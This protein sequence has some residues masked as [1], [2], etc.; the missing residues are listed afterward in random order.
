MLA[1]VA[2]GRAQTVGP[3]AL[4][5]QA[6]DEGRLVT[7]A[8]NT[9]P[10]A[11]GQHD[12]GRVSD[13]LH[14]DMYLQL[15][16]SPEQELAAAQFVESLTDTTSPNFHHWITA[17]EYGR[18]FG[19]APED[20][21]TVSRWLQTHGFTVNTVHANNM[22]IDFSG[23][24]GQV[25]E[26]LHTEIH[27]LDV[28]GERHFANMSDPQI[29][30]ALLP[31]VTG[32]VS[33]SNFKPHSMLVPKAQYTVSPLEL[34]IVPGDLA[35]I[36]NLN[37]AFSAGFTGLG[38]TVV[39]V[40]DTDLYNGTGD[41]SVFRQTF[42]LT[43]Y[44]SGSLT[45]VHP[46]AGAGGTCADPGIND[47]DGEAAL[48]VEWASAAAPNAAIVMASC[49]DTTNF[50]GFIA[51]QNMLTD[52]GALPSVV[53][54][55][56]G[57]S[58]TS[59]GASF[60]AYIDTL[61]Q[62]ATAAGV[63]VFV[64]TGDSA[65]AV[66]DRDSEVAIHGITASSFASTPYNVAVGGT[67]FGDFA[68]GTTSAFW[69]STNGTYYNSAESY[70][71][72]I[73]WNDSCASAVW[74]NYEGVSTTY[75]PSGYCN[76][77]YSLL[78]T[79]GG[80]GGP[81]GCATGSPSLS[82]VVS[83]TCAGY[84]KP[85]WQSIP[86]NP[87]DGVRDLPDV[88]LFASNGFWGHYY[89][90]CIS[91]GASCTGPPSDWAGAGGT[92]FS[93]PIMAGIQAVINQALGTRNVG[94][95]NPVYYQIGQKQYSASGGEAA[96]NSSTGPASTCSFNDVT[97]GDM[98]VPCA[99]VNCYFDGAGIGVLS[100]SSTSYQP[101]F[102]TTPGWDFAT[103]IGTV[104]AFN[105]LNAYVDSVASSVAPP[106]PVLISPANGATGVSP[107]PSLTWNA[108]VGATSYDVYFG[109]ATQPPLVTNTPDIVYSPGTLS[110]GTTYYWAVGAR[111]KLGANASAAR[112]FTTGCVA[113]LNPSSAVAPAGGST[114]TI[115]VNA[116]TGCVW[117][118]ASN[119]TWI[120]ITSGASGSGN[121]TVGYTVAADTAAQRSG[122]IT[123]AGQTFTVTQTIYPLISTLAGGAMPP[124]AAPG[125][126][127]SIPISFGIAVDS[128]GN[129]YFSSPNLNAVF[130]ADP[131]GVVTRIA[132]TGASGYSGDNGPALSATLDSPQGVAV[133]S[134][135]DVYIAD[136]YNSRIRRV[137]AAGTITTV[138]GDGNCC[139]YTGDGGA[140]INAQIGVP[141][142]LAVDSSGDLY[143]SDTFNN[144]VRK[145]AT[146]GIIATVA[147]NGAY[148]YSGDNGPATSAEFKDP[149]SVAVD[150]S[151]NLYIADSYNYRIR[152]VSTAGTITTVAGNGIYG[153]SGDGG[154]AT[155]AEL[156]E[157]YGVAVDA[158]GDLYIAD[159]ANERIRKVNSSGTI[160]TVAGNGAAGY[161]GDGGT[162]TSAE[163]YYPYGVAVS[164]AGSLY[165]SDSGNARIRSV[166]AAGTISTVVGGATGDGGLGEFGHL[167][168]PYGVARDNAGNTYIAD[169]NNN[170]VR[171][172]A[173]NGTITTVAGTGVSGYL[174]DNGPAT[175]AELNSPY[176][177][178]V[179]GSG[180]LYIADSYNSR[181]RKVNS[182]GTITTVAGN[183]AY[184]YSGDGGAA[185]SASLNEPFG[186]AVDAAGDLYI[187]D[188]YN[189]RVRKVNSSGTI[190]TVAGNGTYG[191]S[192][193]GGVATSAELR[194][195][196][197]VAVD[198]SGNV[199]IADSYN[200]RIRMVSTSGIITTVAGNGTYGYS[201]DGGT[202]TSASLFEPTGVAVDSTGDLYIADTNN[203]RIR[204]VTSGTITTVA[205]TGSA[206]YS[207][208]G[209]VATVAELHDPYG[210][211]VDAAGNVAIADWYNNSARLLT[212][213][214]T[215]PVLSIQGA[216]TGAFTQG[217]NGA[218]YTLTVS[219]AFG[220][221]TTSGTVTVN[222]VL[223][224]G[225]TLVSMAGTGWTCTSP[226]ACTR[227]DG[228]NG[229]SSY[230]AIT[231]TVNVSATAPVQ[232]TNQASVSGGGAEAAA[233]ATDLTLISQPG[234]TGSVIPSVT[235][236]PFTSSITVAQALMVTVAVSGG[237]SNPTPT[238]TVIL[239][240]GLY[241]SAAATLSAG[242]AT[243]DIPAGT[244]ATGT[245][246]LTVSYTPD[247]ASS[248]T[249]KGASGSSSVTVVPQGVTTTLALSASPAS[250]SY[251]QQVVLSATLTPYSAQGNST[252][253]ETV[254][255]Y[256]DGTRLGTG[257]LSSGVATLNV[258]AL[259]AGSDGLQAVYAGD[260]NF[261]TSIS[262]ALV[263]PVS[264][265]VP[266]ISF[267]IP[268]HTY[269]DAPFTL[270]ATSNSSGAFTYSVVS[271]PATVSG[272]TATL[273]GAGTVVLQASQAAAGNYAA[274]S[275]NAS[276]TVAAEVPTIGF[277]VPNHTYGDAPFTVAATSN[278]TGAFTYSVV[279]GPATIS[280]SMVT[281]TGAGTVVLQ[282][283]QV[284]AGNYAAGSQ[285][286]PFAVGKNS[287]SV[288]L[289]A[290]P[291]PVLTLNAVS[292]TATVA[293]SA[294][295]PTG[296][297]VFSDSGMTIG[298]A[299]LG[300]GAAAITL[301][302]LAVGPHSITA[303]YSGDTNF[304]SVTSAA[305]PEA[306]EDFTFSTGGTGSS[307]TV[308][309][310]G[311]ASYTIPVSVS[312]GTTVPAAVAFSVS[313]LPTGYTAT[314]TPSS[315]P[316]GSGATNVMLSVQVPQSAVLEENG[317]LM[318]LAAFCVLLLPF[319]GR[320]RRSSKWL[321]R[322]AFVTIMLAGA[323]SVA[324]MLGCVQSKSGGG[325]SSQPQSYTLTV[326]ATSGAL[327]HS[328]A[329]T[330]TVQ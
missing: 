176:S 184:A 140:A 40:E 293:S 304:N 45:Q 122:T 153:Y 296:S 143:L 182:S 154:V 291:N 30:E 60:N 167:N 54:I 22:V 199:Y 238:G 278:S 177:V 115:S 219:N 32:V 252:N 255:F 183:G 268:N 41:W 315:L 263:F 161:S 257:A 286:G 68:S 49:A 206:G 127:V 247:S 168:Q 170:R 113:A 111:N 209:G 311:T 44:A 174:G 228:L 94:N 303:A 16:R 129:T 87:S 218:T 280:G 71:R 2:N 248:S 96:C 271:G 75:G 261:V 295:V 187:A 37:P 326:T 78:S 9:R 108:S 305:V 323:V 319:A 77:T 114:G 181:V 240:S 155:S 241:T 282:A 312:G 180:N 128:S 243:I 133:D 79:I 308:Q 163:L 142:G 244:L 191:Y 318:P 260:T 84:A 298:T 171:K 39:V 147:G 124:T 214:G 74:A 29:P 196:W 146:S 99:G 76:S 19:A 11:T 70:V 85:S 139:S 192:G 66:A 166:S 274:G 107:V 159:I 230:P 56:Y 284:A 14:L 145:V 216:H 313:G 290:S 197:G 31:A 38:Q 98:D 26:A 89:V 3:R 324:G 165:V 301:S 330:L 272:S 158:T 102:G 141:Y 52:G 205:G 220:T 121:G 212:L 325:S 160:A 144:V 316:A 314:F 105:L 17:A 109:T 162:A 179:D 267:S 61:Y 132:G 53:S 65:A 269:G 138:A 285:N 264:A 48:D 188:F 125:A 34:P 8:G 175:S 134:A 58:E 4:I 33:L 231:V 42:G 222:D 202:A 309:P 203:N 47:D 151:G 270:G 101:A 207:G 69:S 223:P 55:S 289:L 172:V 302:T 80:S 25:R 67:D 236:T 208:D 95:P 265:A 193:D 5:T 242:N 7:L 185:A 173:A 24:A 294:G 288:V 194:E 126:S 137:S 112:S 23:N 245:D 251:G 135:G 73:P 35:T 186:V 204:K 13:D 262:N 50:G 210:V 118:A 169:T 275:Q 120:T 195:P 297:V 321:R 106:P 46:A 317:R 81:S 273:T 266:A 63:S 72:E 92:S 213:A 229:G 83:G 123:I 256:S 64:S 189:Y 12:L 86:G 234:S 28:A 103:G 253:G 20:I 164:P 287:P 306:I 226:P 131:T 239:G 322:T 249:Y 258:T 6:I 211:A 1:I 90:F 201:G 250:S 235:V 21:A 157:P 82:G 281:L 97:Q 91:E 15:K 276:F 215:Q 156:S 150:A 292:L 254:T 27:T 232:L 299:N 190:T 259:P 43:Q 237:G 198:T 116:T 10:E 110:P 119:A 117:T 62:T 277:A 59:S 136:S 327:S 93:S 178:A 279:S 104:N 57:E 18:R 36:Y 148:G 307:E 329:V 224:A 310:G 225:L 88:S 217:Q 283:S 233:R 221:G 130:K 320:I 227:S 200:Y 246:T 300:G 51:L 152:K 149:Y 100:A 328:T